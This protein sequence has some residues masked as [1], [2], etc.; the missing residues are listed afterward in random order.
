[1]IMIKTQRRPIVVLEVERKKERS[2]HVRS[3]SPSPAIS[4]ASLHMLTSLSHFASLT[5]AYFKQSLREA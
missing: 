2:S 1:M 5:Y 3:R 4:R